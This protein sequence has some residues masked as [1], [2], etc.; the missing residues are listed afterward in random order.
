MSSHEM[1]PCTHFN[2]VM[3]FHSSWTS[4]EDKGLATKWHSG[5]VLVFSDSSGRDASWFRSSFT[6]SGDGCGAAGDRRRLASFRL[7]R[8]AIGVLIDLAG[9]PK[10][11]LK[12][13]I[14]H[15]HVY[16]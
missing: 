5:S 12:Y 14:V 7:L 4:P 2:K 8:R 3:V 9:E 6:G 1:L 11:S 15:V 13:I 16:S 10:V